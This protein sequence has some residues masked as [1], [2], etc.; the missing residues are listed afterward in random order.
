MEDDKLS[1]YCGT[2]AYMA[3]ELLLELDYSGVSV[4]L[5]AAGIIL[6][7]MYSGTPAFGLAKP[8]DPYYR[9]LCT[10]KHNFFWG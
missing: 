3:P 1:T 2:E 8:S 6:F 7:I 10:N 4:D 5:F 9:L